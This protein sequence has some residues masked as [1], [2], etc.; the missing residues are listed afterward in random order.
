MKWSCAAIFSVLLSCFAFGVT[1]LP[2]PAVVRAG[3]TIALEVLPDGLRDA[4]GHLPLEWVAEDGI[5]TQS[6]AK[7]SGT[8]EGNRL[9]YSAVVPERFAGAYLVRLAMD[10]RAPYRMTVT[11]AV[12]TVRE[13]A[14]EEPD[15][16]VMSELGP[17]RRVFDWIEPFFA[18]EPLYVALGLAAPVDIHFQLSF[19][20]LL[21]SAEDLHFE[22][23]PGQTLEAWR[24]PSG[25]YFAYT[26]TSLWDIVKD[27]SPFRDTSYKPAFYWHGRNLF[28]RDSELGH[29][30]LT[31]LAGVEHESN[32]KDGVDSRSINLAVLRPSLVLTTRGGWHFLV[33]PKLYGYIEKTDNSDIYRYRGYVDLLASVR[34]PDDGLQISLTGRLGSGMN[35]GSLQMDLTYPLRGVGMPGYF[36]IQGFTGYGETLLQ[37]NQRT[38]DQ[39]RIGF[40]AIR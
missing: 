25:L 13:T 16:A 28:T 24:A 1:L 5:A 11:P 8:P 7:L 34:M 39:I 36:L 32:G 3:E 40:S 15:A 26:Q 37:Y 9:F 30:Q 14:E 18:H 2:P 29:W 35:R 31:Y 6:D 4:P 33:S 23:V 38:A 12:A 21:F 19:K 27:S 17:R 20:Y 10:D 22:A